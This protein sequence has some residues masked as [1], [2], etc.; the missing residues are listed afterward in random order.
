MPLLEIRGLVTAF[1]THAALINAVDGIDLTIEPDRTLGL[2]GESG[3][4]KSVTALSI[5]RLIQKPGRIESGEILYDRNGSVIDLARLDPKGPR[6]R[7][8]RG[9]EIAMIFQ[10]PLTSLNPVY[11]I[12]NQIMEVITL[13]QHLRRTEA[14]EKAIEALHAVG[15]PSPG[16]ASTS[17]RTSS[18]EACASGP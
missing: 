14:R 4:G 7:A 15:I 13:H 2:V 3:C 9:N 16:S 6:M 5:L 11:T 18:P 10:E 8:I 12:G 17:I 1:K